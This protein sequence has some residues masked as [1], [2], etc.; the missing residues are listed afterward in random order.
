MSNH[1]NCIINYVMLFNNIVILNLFCYS[2]SLSSFVCFS[3]FESIYCHKDYFSYGNHK[4]IIKYDITH[5]FMAIN[6]GEI[7]VKN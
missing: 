6:N 1:V 5:N 2:F 7:L 4:I 3:L